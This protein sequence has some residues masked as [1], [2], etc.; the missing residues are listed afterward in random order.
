MQEVILQCRYSHN[1]TWTDIRFKTPIELFAE[2]QHKLAQGW[3]VRVHDDSREAMQ[4]S[5]Y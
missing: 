5:E 2:A 1:D 3:E 4:N